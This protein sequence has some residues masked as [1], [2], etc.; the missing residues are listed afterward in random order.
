MGP[1]TAQ[2]V[3]RILNAAYMVRHYARGGRVSESSPLRRQRTAAIREMGLAVR[4][5]FA[6]SEDVEPLLAAVCDGLRPHLEQPF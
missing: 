2:L 4:Q 6:V 1:D 5:A 3:A